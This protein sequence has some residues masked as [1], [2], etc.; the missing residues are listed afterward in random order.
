MSHLELKAYPGVGKYNQKH[1]NYSQTVRI[2]DMVYI[3]GQ[4]ASSPSALSAFP[5]ALR[6]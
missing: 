6:H 3:S 2:G 5:S 1:F 4:G